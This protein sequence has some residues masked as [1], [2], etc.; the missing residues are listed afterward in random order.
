[1]TDSRK[2]R[3]E[4]LCEATGEATKSKATDQAVG[5]YLRMRGNTGAYATGATQEFLATAESEGSVTGEQI[6]ST[7]D[8]PELRVKYEVRTDW[9]VG[10]R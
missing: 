4:S 9:S 3:Y 8:C 5:Y 7:I 2:R 10:D 6:A 1:M